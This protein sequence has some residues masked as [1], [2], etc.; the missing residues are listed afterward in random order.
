VLAIR[1]IGRAACCRRSRDRFQRIDIETWVEVPRP[2]R[3]TPE[4]AALLGTGAGD[5][6]QCLERTYYDGDGRAVETADTVVPD[7]RWEVAYE[8]SAD[9][10]VDGT[11]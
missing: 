2:A 1:A 6:L 4:Q 3:A 7:T 5:L 8:F 9:P 11:R 10:P